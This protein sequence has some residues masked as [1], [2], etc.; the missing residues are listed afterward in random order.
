MLTA[1]LHVEA[2]RIPPTPRLEVRRVLHVESAML[3]SERHFARLG[4]VKLLF[5]Y[6]LSGRT[7]CRSVLHYGRSIVSRNL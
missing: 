4:W 2:M 6:A 3:N 5:T 7:K 1:T